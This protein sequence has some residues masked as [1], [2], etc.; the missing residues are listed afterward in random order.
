[1]I[2]FRGWLKRF[3]LLRT[4]VDTCNKI[5]PCYDKLGPENKT[6]PLPN[7]TFAAEIDN[8][9]REPR[10]TTFSHNGMLVFILL[11]KNKKPCRASLYTVFLALSM[12]RRHVWRL[13]IL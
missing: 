5:A 4:I 1:M 6:F 10:V 3:S 9:H 13:I 11:P 12:S 8:F 2:T 7:N